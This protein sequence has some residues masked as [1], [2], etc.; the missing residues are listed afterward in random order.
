MDDDD[1]DDNDDDD[2][3]NDDDDNGDDDDDGNDDNDVDDDEDD[4]DGGDDDDEDDAH[5]DLHTSAVAVAVNQMDANPNRVFDSRPPT[6][7]VSEKYFPRHWRLTLLD[8]SMH[9]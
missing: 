5:T 2:D 6:I 4:N 9:L 8:A 1:D 3:D 7:Y